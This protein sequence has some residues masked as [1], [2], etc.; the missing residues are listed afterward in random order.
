MYGL[1]AYYRASGDPRARRDLTQLADRRRRD[2]DAGMAVRGAAALD[3]GPGRCGTPW[4]GEMAGALAAAGSA[5][6]RSDW[7]RTAVGE[8]AQFTPHLLVQGG[9]DN[10]WLPA[11]I[12][13]DQ[14][15][16]GADVTLRNLLST[17]DATHRTSFRQLAG[18]AASWYFGNNPA[19]APMYDPATG[20]TNDGISPAGEINLNSGAESTIHGV[21]SMLA[22]DAAPDVA[23]WARTARRHRPR[24]LDVRRGR[25]R[26]AVRRRRRRHARASP[27]RASRSGAVTSTCRW[28]REG[29][30]PSPSS[31]RPGTATS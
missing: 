24:H 8:T 5:L 30:S 22:L 2:E 1:V 15:A 9:P 31:C 16:Y 14:I 17:A 20:V 23:G 28:A 7:T 11:P 3:A 18:V 10:E 4:G 6:G 25:V 29:G 26:A 12:Y 27:G 13:R 21:L 19:H